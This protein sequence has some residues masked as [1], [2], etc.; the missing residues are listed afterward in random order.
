M[1]MKTI[2]S[3]SKTLQKKMKKKRIW[4][5]LKEIRMNIFYQTNRKFKAQDMSGIRRG[6]SL[7]KIR[8]LGKILM[9][10]VMVRNILSL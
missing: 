3:I 10:K 1:M 5:V 4:S 2:R 9:G 6:D 8:E 7:V